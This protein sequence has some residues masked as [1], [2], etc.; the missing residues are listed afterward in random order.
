MNGQNE[1]KNQRKKSN[2]SLLLRSDGQISLFADKRAL[3]NQAGI[4]RGTQ[5]GQV[6]FC[7]GRPQGV[8]IGSQSLEEFLRERGHDEVFR[9]REFL[10][11]QD[12][13]QFTRRYRAGGRP[14]Y[15]PQL[16]TGL[17][18]FG[19][20][21]GKSS[22]RELEDVARFDVRVW[23]LTGGLCPDHSK[24]GRFINL[25]AETLSL[26]FFE[27]VTGRILACWGGGGGDAAVDGTVVQAAA[28]SYRTIREEAARQKAEQARRE[29]EKSPEDAK[30][31]QKA[32]QAERV[33]EAVSERAEARR[34]RRKSTAHTCVSPSEPEAVVQRQKN[35]SVAPCCKPSVLADGKRIILGHAVH[36]TSETRLVGDLL[37]QAG[38][39]GAEVGGV[40]GDGL[41]YDR[42]V[43]EAC[44]QR[45]KL[46]L[47]PVRK[48][49]KTGK[50]PRSMFCYDWLKD[51]Y[52]C[53]AG[54]EMVP[55]NRTR[56]RK[57]PMVAYGRAPC[58]QCSLRKLCTK[59]KKGRR[60]IHYE[61]D[62]QRQRLRQMMSSH[63]GKKRYRP[64]AGMVEPVYSVLKDRQGLRRFR[65]RGLAKGRLEW[66]LHALAYN[67]GR[68]LVL[69]A[70]GA[71][72]AEGLAKKAADG[73][74]RRL[75]AVFSWLRSLPGLGGLETHRKWP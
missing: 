7:T 45:D 60:I 53:P 73:F 12:W 29:A 72:L 39:S 23:W 48:D 5:G 19:I 17:I 24:I 27:A 9:L 1:K 16:M 43:M 75:A 59:N 68:Y 51:V 62:G 34:R 38:R 33:A 47:C 28:S 44:R 71:G 55:V 49:K 40:L 8:V 70:P 50:F 65:R 42:Q 41:Y 31:Q 58:G 54:H 52:L 67:L 74:F 35:R 6:K 64:R 36:P 18:V 32:A 14:A 20:L 4:S 3:K 63:Q 66:A 10:E 69:T 30:A 56:H 22:L 11:Q 37:D 57:R 2:R 15:D 25:H 46:L 21:Q 61:G 13:S 26:E